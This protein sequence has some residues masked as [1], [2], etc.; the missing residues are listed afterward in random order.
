MS[1]QQTPAVIV[2]GTVDHRCR[3][4]KVLT[5]NC[6]VNLADFNLFLTILSLWVFMGW[7]LLA[8]NIAFPLRVVITFF[9]AL[10]NELPHFDLIPVCQ[11]NEI[12]QM[13][14]C[15]HLD[16]AFPEV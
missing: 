10:P 2:I 8:S 15:N 6:L 4:R 13:S 14:S 12:I 5:V 7:F 9:K 11:P 16:Q 1:I 3:V